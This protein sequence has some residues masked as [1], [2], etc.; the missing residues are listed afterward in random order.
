MLQHDFVGEFDDGWTPA[1][2][3]PHF[4]SLGH[5]DEYLSGLRQEHDGYIAYADVELG[6]L[7]SSMEESGV[8]DDTCVVITSDQGEMFERGIYEHVTQTLVDPV[9][10]VPL[11]ISQPGQ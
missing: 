10:H 11:V 7:L 5:S 4:F 6:R 2:K 3:P 8:M 9:I 1:A